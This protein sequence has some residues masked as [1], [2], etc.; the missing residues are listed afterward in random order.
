MDP[1]TK[2]DIEDI[3]LTLRTLEQEEADL[4]RDLERVRARKQEASERL[5]LLSNDEKY[6]QD[7]LAMVYEQ[8]HK[9]SP[10]KEK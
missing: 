10:H 5:K 8:R 3:K 9:G 2:R 7:M 6:Q 4:L 1:E